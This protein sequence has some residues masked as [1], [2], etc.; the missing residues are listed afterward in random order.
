[1]AQSRR[2]LRAGLGFT[3]LWVV[4]LGVFTA[5]PV[6]ASVYYSFCDYSVLTS[7]LWIGTE[8]YQRLWQDDLFWR[9]LR[10]TLYFA[11]FS[12]PLGAIASLSLALLL[13]Q[14]VR[15]RPV[16]RA[17][18][19]LPSIVP[20]VASSMLW[21]W[22]F[23]GQ[24][25]LLNFVLTPIL[26][27][28]GLQPPIWLADPNWAKPAL[29]MM[30][31]WGVGNSMIIYLAGL[32]DVPKELYESADIDGAGPWRKFWHITLPCISPVIYFN[33]LMGTI[34]ALQV[35]T[36]AFIMSGGT[37]DGSPAR[38][39]LFYALYLFGQAFYQLRMGYAS[40]MAWILFVMIV[41]LTWLA[42]KLS[43]KHVHYNR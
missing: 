9:A 33:V 24:Y 32:Q 22:I 3:A 20:A 10:N 2:Q 19:Y 21:L 13:N 17:L 26:S 40:A 15:G 18:F 16:F 36:Q 38:S 8:N 29:V 28:I 12:V 1:M 41:T 14:E 37:D 39:T 23:N 6:L 25:G 34:G 42:T 4:G 11:V 5:Y 35:F 43:A 7:P 27:L 31:L 30:S